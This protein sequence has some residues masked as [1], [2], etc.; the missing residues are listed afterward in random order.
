MM[1]IE[2]I[3]MMAIMIEVVILLLISIWGDDDG[4]ESDD[5]RDDDD[6]DY[7]SFIMIIMAMIFGTDLIFQNLIR[8]RP[9]VLLFLALLLEF[10]F[11][12]DSP[13][14]VCRDPIK[15]IVRYNVH[16]Y[17]DHVLEEGF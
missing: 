6:D 8:R 17:F 11:L 10:S 13:P 3:K 16:F 4:D 15:T 5:D 2:M 9:F 12:Q 14:P 1:M 7:Y